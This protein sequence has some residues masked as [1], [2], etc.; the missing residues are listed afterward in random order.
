MPTLRFV[1]RD[2]QHA[3]ILGPTL[4][5][6]SSPFSR[7]YGA[8]TLPALV[9]K[10]P[11]QEIAH[12]EVVGRHASCDLYGWG[13]E[14]SSREKFNTRSSSTLSFANIVAITTLSVF[15]ELVFSPPE[16]HATLGFTA[17]HV[18]AQLR[19]PLLPLGVPAV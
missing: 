18:C 16:V 4:R 7:E 2:L 5:E 11:K 12:T 1:D 9:S 17:D 3:L 19:S 10:I 6:G 15:S 8:G 14:W 13:C